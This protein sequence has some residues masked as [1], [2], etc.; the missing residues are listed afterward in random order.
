M[1]ALA[2]NADA[3]VL[4]NEKNAARILAGLYEFVPG[5]KHPKPQ[6]LPAR[7]AQLELSEPRLQKFASR[8]GRVQL[9]TLGRGNHFL[10]FQ[11]DD[12]AQLWIMIHSGS[13][14]IGQAI[15]DYHRANSRVG[16]SGLA[17][18][19]SESDAGKRY[20]A[21]VQWARTYAAQNRLTMLAA[22]KKLMQKLFGITSDERTL[23]HCDHN[24]VRQESHACKP[25]W[26]HRKGAQA[27]AFD[28]PG[29]IPG[30]MGTASFHT[31]GRGCESALLSSSHGA[32]RALSRTDARRKVTSKDF[33]RQ[34][35][36]LWY[37]HRI[38]SKL[39]DEAPA[40]YKDIRRV[41]KAQHNLTR[42]V[43]ELRP[44]LSYKGV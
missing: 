22:A 11:S 16:D 6:N 10:E 1:L 43:R 15:A 37:D 8:D 24:H 27:A 17:F 5:N 25:L 41:M 31:A 21:D 19:D 36:N 33:A 2:F 7:L 3:S 34:V 39:R 4:N 38:A 35:G 28:E 29:I 32:G 20:L 12:N 44:L 26:I 14:A 9:G 13:R 30:S 23:I 40:A 42:I 18:L